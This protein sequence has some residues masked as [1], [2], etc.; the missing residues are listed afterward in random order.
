MSQ[1]LQGLRVLNTRPSE[2]AHILTQSITAAGGV[3]IECPALEIIPSEPSWIDLL[4]DLNRANFA[5]F[6]SA[7][8]VRH[9]FSQLKMHHLIWPKQIKVIA[10][11]QGSAK[12]LHELNIQ[13]NAIP[14]FPDS[15]H[16][17]SLSCLHQLKNQTVLLFKGEEGRQ[18][19]EEG[20]R[21]REAN[22]FILSVYKRVMPKIR[23]QFM[24]TLWRDDLV[25]IIL[26][27]SEQSIRNL[28]TMFG[29]EA[30]NWLIKK[31][32]VVISERLVNTAKSFGMT[33]IIISHPERMMKT[34]VDYY[35]G[36]IHGQE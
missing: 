19:I 13:V 22:L 33:E 9:C 23:H 11:G 18:L 35:Q 31:P 25:D 4:P 5:V 15:E 16:L 17:L 24:T 1:L 34:L 28:F 30:R 21:Q 10:I 32:V 29:E 26:L 3:S 36:L 2:S 27:T 20:L 12:A 8:A 7:N 6:I 14:K